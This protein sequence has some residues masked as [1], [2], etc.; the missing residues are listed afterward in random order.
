MEQRKKFK[1]VSTRRI[2]N[3][4]NCHKLVWIWC[5]TR[6]EYSHIFLF[7]SEILFFLFIDKTIPHNG[8][9]P[10]FEVSA[11][12]KSFLTSI[13]THQCVLEKVFGIFPVF[14]QF[15]GECEKKVFYFTYVVIEIQRCHL[16]RI[17]WF[18]NGRKFRLLMFVVNSE[19]LNYSQ[20]SFDWYFFSI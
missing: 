18:N 17:Y 2:Q 8:C 6:C 16:F 15:H 13:S 20:F 7:S 10:R 11:F 12:L 9:D 14:G 4:S 3:R 5:E 1:G 19:C